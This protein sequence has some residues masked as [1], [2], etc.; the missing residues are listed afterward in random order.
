MPIFLAKKKIANK[1]VKRKSIIAQIILVLLGIEF[2]FLA[3][4]TAFNLPTA[5]RGN[6]QTFL[7]DRAGTLYGKFSRKFKR[8]CQKTAPNMIPPD[9][10]TLPTVRYSTYVPQAP[11]AIFV[12]YILGW[13]LALVVSIGYL[14]LGLLGPIFKLYVFAGG[15][16]FNY[17]LQPGFGY[18]LG[19]AVASGVVGWFS[20]GPRNS[21]NQILSMFMGLLSI[22][23]VG[24]IYLL[25]ICLFGALNEST[26]QQLVWSSWAFEEAR[27]LTWYALPYDALFAIAFIGLAF[28]FRWLTRILTS[29]DLGVPENV[30]DSEKLIDFRLAR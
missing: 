16:G 22:H 4:F 7:V 12:G 14:L 21:I 3:G 28:P 9:P 6:I 24:L 11:A 5:T 18:L 19:M 29:P 30:A 15:S 8:F 1:R 20:R 2:L 13:P 17:Y 10:A 26:G 27:N 25:G 23:G